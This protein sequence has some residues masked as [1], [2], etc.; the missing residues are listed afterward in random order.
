VLNL[1]LHQMLSMARVRV[2]KLTLRFAS[3]LQSG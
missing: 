2:L 1:L 3:N